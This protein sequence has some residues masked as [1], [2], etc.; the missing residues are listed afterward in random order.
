MAEVPD[1][2]D[3]ADDPLLKPS[4]VAAILNIHRA[5]L[6][7]WVDRG[8][9]DAVVLPSGVHRFRRSDVDRILGGAA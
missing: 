6:A 2:S 5:T 9:I 8:L 1:T 7:S 3:R 4:E